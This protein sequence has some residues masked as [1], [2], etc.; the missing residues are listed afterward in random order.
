VGW[1]EFDGDVNCDS[2]IESCHQRSIK[3]KSTGNFENFDSKK[4]NSERQ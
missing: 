1:C 2:P 4:D 3:Q